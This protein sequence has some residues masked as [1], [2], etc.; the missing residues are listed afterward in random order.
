MWNKDL[1]QR[2]AHGQL[3]IVSAPAGSGKTTLVK[4]LVTTFPSVVQVPTVTT[5]SQRKDEVEGKDYHFVSRAE[6]EQKIDRGELLEHIELHGQLYGTLRA[7]V[8]RARASGYHVVLVIDTR[9]AI[10]LKKLLN[11]VLIFIKP[12]SLEALRD[13]LVQRGSEDEESLKARLEWAKRELSE[14]K[15]FHYSIIND[16]LKRAFDT[17]ASVFVAE[18]HRVV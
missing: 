1:V 5:R 13:R 8:E 2:F 4:Q 10:A 12:P 9:G 14:E 11:P 17:L 3:F 7:E 16:D 18:T 6:F 15:Q